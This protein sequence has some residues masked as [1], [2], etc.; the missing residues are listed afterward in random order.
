MRILY[1]LVLVAG[2][3]SAVAHH[4]PAQFDQ[5]SFVVIEG[6]VTEFSWG[7]PHVYLAVETTGLRGERFVQ[8]VE[9]GPA[10][11]LLPRGVTRD[12]LRAGDTVT[13]RANPNRRGGRYVV[14]GVQLTTADGS[15]FP[16]HARALRA[17]GSGDEVATSIEGTWVP[18]PESYLRLAAEMRSWPMTE[19]AREVLAGD[20]SD[21]LAMQ[22]ACTPQGPPALMASSGLIAVAADYGMVTFDVD[23]AQVRRVVHIGAEHPVGLQPTLLGHSIG[24]WDGTALVVDTIG[25]TP[26]PEGMGFGFPSSEAKRIV[27]RFSLS[28]DGT[29]LD[30]QITAED[31]TYLTEAV[32]YRTR[33]DYRPGQ[34]ATDAPCDPAVAL[35]F[36]EKE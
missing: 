16:L 21:M 7:N 15:R 12:L 14:L 3:F 25:F 17:L 9:A 36:L 32:T 24:W 26:H 1:V 11:Q 10:S 20:R 30:Y 23:R 31:S 28:D 29:Q 19:R 8:Q 5:T 33:W 34:T 18:Q 2:P 13:V 6:T 4:S 22:A 35:R 27:E